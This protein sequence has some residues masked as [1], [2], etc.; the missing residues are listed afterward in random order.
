M[1]VADRMLVLK[2]QRN[3]ARSRNEELRIE[4]A[5]DPLTGLLN[6]RGIEPRYAELREQGFDTLAV[7]DL[8]HFKDVNDRFGHQKGDDVLVAVGD[9]LCGDAQRQHIAAR[10]G[11]EEF[12]VLL[13]GPETLR[14]AEALRRSITARV[15]NQVEG[16]DRPI[17]CS[18]G[19]IEIPH[20]GGLPMSFAALYARADTLLYEAK[21]T[22]RNR[23]VSERLTV[24]GER[25]PDTPSASMAG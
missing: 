19:V 13:R 4:A 7:L 15:A 22:G 17:T 18:M 2:R 9:A 16:L 25:P 21:A 3:V 23:G 8:D 20:G 10:L 6:R 14:R 24:F 11:G 1:G 5:H 12:M